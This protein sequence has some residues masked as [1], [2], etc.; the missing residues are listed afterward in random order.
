MVYRV[1]GYGYAFCMTQV[2]R[3]S[4]SYENGSYTA[5][6]INAPIVTCGHTLEELRKN[7]REAVALFLED[8]VLC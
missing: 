3:F 7:I 8:E 5:N 4:I 2:I 6:G 1:A